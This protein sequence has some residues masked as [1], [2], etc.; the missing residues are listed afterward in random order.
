M[1]ARGSYVLT[2]FDASITWDEL[3]SAVQLP[4]VRLVAAWDVAPVHTSYIMYYN[5][6]YNNIRLALFTM[7]YGIMSAIKENAWSAD[8]GTRQRK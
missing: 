3:D 6:K 1:C 2:N 5:I 8:S 7:I 4:Y